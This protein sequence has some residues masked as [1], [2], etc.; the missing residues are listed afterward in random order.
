M[1]A[2][3]LILPLLRSVADDLNRLLSLKDEPLGCPLDYV[4]HHARFQLAG[5]PVSLKQLSWP[6]FLKSLYRGERRQ[7]A[8]GH[9]LGKI[10]FC[11][12]FRFF[13]DGYVLHTINSYDFFQV[14]TWLWKGTDSPRVDVGNYR[15]DGRHVAFYIGPHPRRID[16]QGSFE[17]D[18][19]HLRRSHSVTR[20]QE[21]GTFRRVTRSGALSQI[22]LRGL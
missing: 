9:P 11:E 15:F 6:R 1:N 22:L 2:S 10:E 21:S 4:R 19:L 17:H 14:A 7:F 5:E 16:Y 20:T 18:I 13:P 12:Y 3:T 8:D